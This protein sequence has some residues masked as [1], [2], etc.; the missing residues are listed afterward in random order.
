LIV[1]GRKTGERFQPV[2]LYGQSMKVS[3]LMI[4]LK[5]PKRARNTWP[6]ICSGEDIIW[7]P[8]YRVSNQVAIKPDS[9]KIVQLILSRDPTA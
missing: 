7:V 6:L 5:I 3:D 2:G 4:N 8:G 9:R 1:R